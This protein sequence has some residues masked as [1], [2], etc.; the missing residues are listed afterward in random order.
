MTRRHLGRDSGFS[1]LLDQL[2]EPSS[3]SPIF[4][5]VT[6]LLSC[7][8][9]LGCD[10]SFEMGLLCIGISAEYDEQQEDIRNFEVPIPRYTSSGV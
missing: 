2:L 1:A 3:S 4:D 8:S 10:F 7:D 5:V 6:W 9:G